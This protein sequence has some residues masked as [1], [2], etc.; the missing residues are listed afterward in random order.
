MAAKESGQA[1]RIGGDAKSRE[2]EGLTCK[3]HQ[4]SHPL[5]SL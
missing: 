2:V 3:L 1:K 5:I 4:M